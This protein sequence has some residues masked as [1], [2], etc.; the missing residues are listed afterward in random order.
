MSTAITSSSLPLDSTMASSTSSTSTYRHGKFSATIGTIVSAPIRGYY[1]PGKVKAIKKLLPPIS[2]PTTT[3]TTKLPKDSSENANSNNNNNANTNN[4]NTN[5]QLIYSIQFAN[6]LDSYKFDSMDESIAI[7]NEQQSKSNIDNQQS[8]LKDENLILDYTADQLIGRGFE[9]ITRALLSENQKVFITFRNREYPASVLKHNTDTD[10]VTL[11]IDLP[12]SSSS[13]TISTTT[14][15]SNTPISSN[16]SQQQREICVVRLQE[17]R[18]LPSRKSAR[19]QEHPD[20]SLL[21]SNGRRSPSSNDNGDIPSTT[22]MNNNANNK[23]NKQ[24]QRNQSGSSIL[25]TNNGASDEPNLPHQQSA[26]IDVPQSTN[27]RFGQLHSISGRKR[28][29]AHQQQQSSSSSIDT[30]AISRTINSNNDGCGLSSASTEDVVMDECAAALVLMSLSASPRSPTLFTNNNNSTIFNEQFPNGTTSANTPTKLFKC[31]WRGCKHRTFVQHEIEQHVRLEHLQKQNDDEE[32]MSGDEEFYYTEVDITFDPIISADAIVALAKGNANGFGGGGHPAFSINHHHNNHNLSSGPESPVSVS[33][34]GDGASISSSSSGMMIMS[35]NG[36]NSMDSSSNPPSPTATTATMNIG[37]V[38]NANNHQYQSNRFSSISF[39]PVQNTYRHLEDHEY[40]RKPDPAGIS[41]L[42]STTIPATNMT[43]TTTNNTSTTVINRRGR[44]SNNNTTANNQQTTAIGL[45]HQ[46]QQ[47]SH[48]INIPNNNN[49]HMHQ[50]HMINS[51]SQSSPPLSSSIFGHSSSSFGGFNSFA[52]SFNSSGFG[53]YTG[54][55]NN[56]NGCGSHITASSS[57]SSSFS[58]ISP[59]SRSHSGSFTSQSSSSSSQSSTSSSITA[60]NKY[61]RISS[62]NGRNIHHNGHHHSHH[63]H[64][65]HSHHNN[66]HH[67][68]S[69]PLSPP[70]TSTSLT[71]HNNVNNIN[72]QHQISSTTLIQQ[73]Q[74]QHRTS[75]TKRVRG[76]TRKCRKVYGMDK[77]DSWCTQCK[78]KKACSRFTD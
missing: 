24:R 4:A 34:C 78:W 67:N 50:D 37:N 27:N 33:E 5:G 54:S 41:I 66:H 42:G 64:N 22:T 72:G 12:P 21:A 45:I 46:H 71:N 55:S 36:D 53:S 2:S 29:P 43:T 6:P 51:I 69:T 47:S 68:G 38:I 8:I 75:P 77:K 57:L 60:G 7:G 73:Q 23:T 9:P 13:T 32:M 28:R 63:P 30:K 39:V 31:T 65:H 61:L 49:N 48:P 76:E 19:I 20:Y 10:D 70:S 15:S 25:L 52:S 26:F 18:L 16:D 40:N 14:N 58:P 59:T 74:Q 35:I 44:K 62:L 3:T 1:Y 11:A 56:G 17:I